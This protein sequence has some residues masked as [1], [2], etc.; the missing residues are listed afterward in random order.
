MKLF[1]IIFY[2]C[3][4]Y[5]VLFLIALFA[6][7]FNEKLRESLIGRFR[8][9]NKLK[10][11]FNKTN[12]NANIYW[13]HVASLGE[14]YQAL[15]I[16]EKLKKID[17]GIEN[18]VSFSSP[19]G[20]DNSYSSAISLKVY[21]PLDFFWSVLF[22]INI[23]KPKKIIFSSYDLWPNLV[24]V[25]EHKGIHSNL[26]AARFS[27][28][29]HA[30]WYPKKLF[31]LLIHSSLSSIY[32]IDENDS[33][34]LSKMIGKKFS[35]I[36]KVLGNPRYDYVLEKSLSLNDKHTMN[37]S[38]RT[39]RII[40][41]S[42]HKEEEHI[43]IPALTE[44]MDSHKDL[45]ILYV[46]HEPTTNEITR[47]KAKFK[48]MNYVGS[49]FRKKTD[50]SLPSERLVILGIVGILSKL[51]W[52]SIIAYV[53]GGFGRGIHN[54]MEPAVAGIPVLFGPKHNHAHE[55]IELI[56]SGGGFCV[57]NKYEFVNRM[58]KLILDEKYLRISG[59]AASH[60]IFKNQG[61]ADK[62]VNGIL[63]D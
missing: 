22:A 30:L 57:K 58:E 5:P 14:Y 7:L 46:P 15:P 62:I 49:V 51:Y 61:S 2:N 28:K 45:K 34:N 59:H 48:E 23:I 26:F 31:A 52:E 44:L 11:Y 10:N 36:I 53:G 54:V 40:I 27:E 35:P 41:G 9:K 4:L 29:N 63:N 16:M 50:I 60:V 8:S 56:S 12:P 3:F 32:V 25:A 19:S 6:S 18:I 24:W 37:L 13:F 38:K 42:I 1:F 43:I 33:Y 47:V 21:I 55:A 17:N 39:K 20:Y